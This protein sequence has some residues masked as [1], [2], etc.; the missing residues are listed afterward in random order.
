MVTTTQPLSCQQVRFLAAIFVATLLGFANLTVAQEAIPPEP[1]QEKVRFSFNKTPWSEVLYWVADLNGLSFNLDYNPAGSLTFVDPD[2]EYTAK[3]AMDEIN[4]Q[5]LARGYT[6]LRRNRSL[7]ILDVQEQLDQKLIRD[8]LLETPIEELDKRGVFELAKVR[9]QLKAIT[10][11]AGKEQIT[12]LI[13]PQGSI[14]TIPLARQLLVTDTGQNLRRIRDTLE[15]V[16]RQLGTDGVQA[17]QLQ[18]TTADEVIPVAKRLLNIEEDASSAEDNSISLSAGTKGKVVY[19]TGTPDK[20]AILRNLV[21]QIDGVAADAGSK[22][23]SF[24][25]HAVRRGDPQMV[26]RV[27]QTLLSGDPRVRLQ[28]G[29]DNIMAYATL[30]QH[31]AI[32]GAIAE[33]ELAPTAVEI[34]PLRKN[35]PV[36]VAALVEGL[37]VDEDDESSPV[38]D[39]MFEPDR[40]VVKGS[41]AQIDQI[42][43]VLSS[44]GERI[45]ASGEV[46][47][48]DSRLLPIDSA[49]FPQAV[50]LL[51]RMYG[52]R[53][54]V[55]NQ[56]DQ[57]LISVVPRP[58]DEE[59][60]QQRDQQEQA[61]QR[62][63]STR[64]EAT[65]EYLDENETTLQ[66]APWTT[67]FTQQPTP[68]V[69]LA[70]PTPSQQA[71][72]QPPTAP[73]D[74]IL[75]L[76][77]EGLRVVSSD[78][79]A[80]AT[81]EELLTNLGM[82]GSSKYHLF[83]LKHVE[84]EA[85]KTQLTSLFTEASPLDSA[86][87][88]DRSGVMGLMTSGTGGSVPT[89]IT[90]TRLN[91]LFVKG[92]VAQ[93]RE[94]T[95]YLKFIDVASGPVEVETSPK[96]SYIPVYFQNAENIVEILKS[97]YADRVSD[98]NSQNRGGR[99]GFPFGRG[100]QQEDTETP[101]MTLAA[102]TVSNMVIVS[103]PGALLREVEQVVRELDNR[104]QAAPSES[105]QVFRLEPGTSPAELKQFLKGSYGDYIQTEGDGIAATESTGGGRTNSR[106]SSNNDDAAARRAAFFQMMRGGGGRPSFG[107]G[108]FGGGRPSFGGGGGR[109]GS[110]SGRGGRGGGGRGGRGG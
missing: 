76:T 72:A 100:G 24:R 68:N 103:A 85:A 99:G 97:L 6:L 35:D 52:G 79:A 62:D 8:L 40:L 88:G 37:F 18:Y 2:R 27:V 81:V 29:A 105:F 66:R 51:R 75:S 19:A 109:G 46:L 90:D 86:S 28:T 71:P 65:E 38:I 9:F 34:I 63:E 13:G 3:E 58:E 20:L 44:V 77:P 41:V 33:I 50:E 47:G 55:V 60:E 48:P 4:G 15:T 84:A 104:A 56:F 59:P 69:Q 17:F 94:V 61:P 12:Q 101:K 98:G 57:P 87:S 73:A 64:P 80:V 10:A 36:T 74:V 93:I 30:D 92:T 42:K 70:Q 32:Q 31:E 5:L 39:A 54:R 1:S 21:K 102:D 16:E 107:G 91:R 45:S 43:Q 106:T 22:K 53:I 95:E 110:T 83:H 78:P 26:L 49:S 96:P 67:L 7:Y 25:S 82:G 11:E 89:M 14:V 108:G 23:L